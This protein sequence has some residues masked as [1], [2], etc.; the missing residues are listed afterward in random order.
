M[1]LSAELAKMDAKAIAEQQDRECMESIGR[2]LMD[3]LPDGYCYLNCPSEIVVDLSNERDE[4]KA[5]L[6]QLRID[7]DRACARVAELEAANIPQPQTV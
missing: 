6:D 5:E 7:Y 4:F 3:A 1:G 2:A